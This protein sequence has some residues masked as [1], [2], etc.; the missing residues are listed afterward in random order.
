MAEKQAQAPWGRIWAWW[1]AFFALSFAILETI[2]LIDRSTEDTLSEN[3][4]R[5][6]GTNKSPKTWGAVGFIV[7]LV[8]FVV[9]FIPHIVFN[10]G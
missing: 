1:L 2:A 3:T 5:W 6:L 7:A 10:W 9:W 4:R 8:G